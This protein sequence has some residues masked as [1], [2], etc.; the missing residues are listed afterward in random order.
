MLLVKIMQKSYVLM[1]LV[2]CL[3]GCG[4]GDNSSSSTTSSTPLF[5]TEWF[6][7]NHD[8]VVDISLQPINTSPY[9]YSIYK[10]RI[11]KNSQQVLQYTATVVVK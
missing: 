10:D 11:S 6:A 2:S 8:I 5:D 3:A 7:F 9:R 4:G 1:F